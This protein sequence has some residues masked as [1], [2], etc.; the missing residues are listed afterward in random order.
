M[1]TCFTTLM[2]SGNQTYL[3]LP[4]PR[5]SLAEGLM[6]KPLSLHS[7]TS[8]S[9]LPAICKDLIGSAVARLRSSCQSAEE[10]ESLADQLTL[11]LLAVHRAVRSIADLYEHLDDDSQENLFACSTEAQTHL[12]KATSAVER[13]VFITMH[14]VSSIKP[15]SDSVSQR[16]EELK[17]E[18]KKIGGY[19]QLLIQRS[20]VDSLRDGMRQSVTDLLLI[21]QRI[22][23]DMRRDLSSTNIPIQ[24]SNVMDVASTLQSYFCCCLSVRLTNSCCLLLRERSGCSAEDRSEDDEGSDLCAIQNTTA[25]LL[26]LNQAIKD[27]H[28]SLLRSL[29][30]RG[31]DPGLSPTIQF[32]SKTIDDIINGIPREMA[33]RRSDSLQLPCEKNIMAARDQVHSALQALTTAFDKST[34]GIKMLDTDREFAQPGYGSRNR[35]VPKV[36]YSL[37]SGISACSRDARWV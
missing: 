17:T 9:A 33:G 30:G 29:K 36:V 15:S 32:L 31:S 12:V 22:T 4:Q 20:V 16:A 37:S 6:N 8:D 23:T 11:D 5:L 35:T 1:T 25:K 14:W 24:K 27:L 19:L 10:S 28:S 3:P 13:A 34:D 18:V 7:S 2:M 26:T 21:G